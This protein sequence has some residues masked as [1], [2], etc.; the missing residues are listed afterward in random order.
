MRA[1]E[2]AAVNTGAAKLR[3]ST[4]PAAPVAGAADDGGTWVDR[5]CNEWH[6]DPPRRDFYDDISRS[7]ARE[8]MLA[9]LIGATAAQGKLRCMGSG[10]CWPC[11]GA[12]GAAGRWCEQSG[13][14]PVSGVGPVA[15]NTL[16]AVDWYC[17][18]ATE[19]ST[20]GS[21]A[22]ASG[23]AAARDVPALLVVPDRSANQHAAE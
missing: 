10:L 9:R 16:Q 5:W 14:A 15:D 20:D 22:A 12:H 4:R 19:T 18:G 21:A 23:I 6:A 17:P 13:D 3:G 2:Y 7:P 8:M 1:A 11:C